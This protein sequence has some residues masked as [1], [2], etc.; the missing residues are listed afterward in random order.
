M[1]Y[2]DN[3]DYILKSIKK[4]TNNFTYFIFKHKNLN[5]NF[6][7]VYLPGTANSLLI[8][9]NE[10]TINEIAEIRYSLNGEGCFV[11]QFECNSKFQKQGFGKLL[12]NMA[13]SHADAKGITNTFGYITPTNE[14]SGI[15]ELHKDKNIEEL[16]ALKQVYSK[17]GCSIISNNEFPGDT[18]FEQ[19]W[20]TGE[21]YKNLTP[22]QTVFL[23][24]MLVLENNHKKR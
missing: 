21:K 8:Y 2:I 7:C 16:A 24:K 3:F 9:E 20:Q 1:T 13:L 23:K 5:E 10:H 18:K 12:F 6:L 17:M 15:S 22:K 19:S 4:F 11:S 14:I